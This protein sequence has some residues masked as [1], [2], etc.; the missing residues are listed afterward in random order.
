MKE[1]ALGRSRRN[2]PPKP[3]TRNTEGAVSEH[4]AKSMA[5][6]WLPR[7]D[8]NQEPTGP[9]PAVLPITPRGIGRRSLATRV[10][11]STTSWRP[12]IPAPWP[13]RAG[14]RQP[15]HPRH[16]PGIGSRT[17]GFPD[18]G[19]ASAQPPT[20][21]VR[22]RPY[23]VVNER[24]GDLPWNHSQTQ[25]TLTVRAVARRASRACRGSRSPC[26]RAARK[27]RRRNR[28][29]PARRANSA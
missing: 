9:K 23:R 18:D 4:V 6:I 13:D 15:V 14:R 26:R 2:Q 3:S 1:L 5:G 29:A 11:L 20:R 7:L 27:W 28:S 25:P 17:H 12:L 22:K 8:S 10:R 19:F 21:T 16:W 24:I